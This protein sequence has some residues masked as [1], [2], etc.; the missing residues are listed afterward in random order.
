MKNSKSLNLQGLRLGVNSV[1]ALGSSSSLRKYEKLNLADNQISDYGMHSVKS[2]LPHLTQINLA[3]NMISGA[4]LEQIMDDLI[5]NITLKVIDLGVVEGSIR[6]NSLGIQGA[7]C[8]SA[9]MIRNKHLESLSLNDNDLGSDG[10]E[11][12]GIALHKN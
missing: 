4:G 7:I 11:C 3:S 5:K 6:K 10:G 1:I 2:L 9:L 8:I 12:L